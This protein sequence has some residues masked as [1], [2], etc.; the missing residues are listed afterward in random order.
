MKK[1]SYRSS[2]P[3]VALTGVAL[4]LYGIAKLRRNPQF[5][6][7]KVVVISGGSRGLG[8]VMARQLFAEGASVA[9]LARD[10][11][12]LARAE[13]DLA[14]GTGPGGI[15]THACD[16]TR[17]EQIKEAVAAIVARFGRIDVLFNVAG[18]ISVGPLEHVR[19]EDFEES[20]RLHFSGHLHMIWAALPHLRERR[21][22]RIVNVASIGG[23]IAIPHL[24][25]YSASKFALVGLSDA[26][27]TEL[28]REGIK[29]STVCPGL[30]RTGSQVHAEFKGQH[31]K[32]FDWFAT[33]DNFPLAGSVSAEDAARQI[34]EAARTGRPA[35][36]FPLSARAME[37]G[38][39]LFPNLTARALVL[40]NRFLLPAPDAKVPPDADT[41]LPGRESRSM[42]TTPA[43]KTSIVDRAAGRNNE[44]N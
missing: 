4:A 34:I 26:L 2:R 27:R 11:E 20:M 39:V 37:I 32:E 25:T 12:E 3:L 28:A 14:A 33:S 36:T 30:L 24:A 31:N 9:L 17:P 19:L 29:V 18:M 1:S 13:A 16:L 40:A 8:L 22:A 23:K 21:D 44:L 7:G 42:E 35:L 10:A 41:N 15:F 38:A 6:A 43:W 5:F